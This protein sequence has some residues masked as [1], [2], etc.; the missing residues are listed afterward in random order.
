[1][2]YMD[3]QLDNYRKL[4]KEIDKLHSDMGKV[5]K[6]T[7][8]DFKSRGPGW[9]S[10]EIMNEYGIKKKDINEN[11]KGVRNQGSIKISGVKIDNMSVIYRGRV[12]TPTH[13]S[14]KPTKRRTKNKPYSITAEIRRG[15]RRAFGKKAFL[16]SNGSSKMI[17]FTR[18]GD[19]RYPIKA[20]KT[21]SVPQMI[22][23]K[24]VNESIAKRIDK[25]MAKR[26][27]YHLQR[28]KRK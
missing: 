1:M 9:I 10:Q 28:E 6:R 19:T 15:R 17:P 24:D 12:L 7:V 22:T 18:E 27:D 2:G 20:I 11:K 26:L 13:F 3:I 21:I 23:N 16:A 5:L 14:M 4:N 25:E 8:S